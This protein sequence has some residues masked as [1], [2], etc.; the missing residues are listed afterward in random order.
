MSD[1]D[2]TVAAAPSALLTAAHEERSAATQLRAVA[3]VTLDA[4]VAGDP[5]C[6]E[7][8]STAFQ[9]LAAMAIATARG[10]DDLAGALVRAA[11]A[12]AT[13]DAIAVAPR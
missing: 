4:S 10:V 12:Y 1:P 6:G 13:S 3:P 9:A 11:D 5:A 2:E 7:A 8:L